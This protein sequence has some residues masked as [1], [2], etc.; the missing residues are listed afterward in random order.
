MVPGLYAQS[1]VEQ[2]IQHEQCNN[3]GSVHYQALRYT[4]DFCAVLRARQRVRKQM[5]ARVFDNTYY[6]FQCSSICVRHI[7]LMNTTGRFFS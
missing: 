3:R 4:L 2:F 7:I 5:Y 1:A 6:A